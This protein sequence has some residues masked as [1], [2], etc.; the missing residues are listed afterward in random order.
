MRYLLKNVEA[1]FIA[2]LGSA[3]LM[4]GGAAMA[5]EKTAPAAAEGASESAPLDED[6]TTPE[7]AAAAA[8]D[9]ADSIDPNAPDPVLDSSSAG[10][11]AV[12]EEA[13]SS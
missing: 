10:T 9:T 2:G 6:M 13:P 3:A 8:D 7:D 12:E 4:T 1:V 11:P 5:Q